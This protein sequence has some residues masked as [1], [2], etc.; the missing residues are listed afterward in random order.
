[1][2]T[3]RGRRSAAA[4]CSASGVLTAELAS[5]LGGTLEAGMVDRDDVA[6]LP[7]LAQAPPGLLVVP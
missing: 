1:M 6:P 7:V 4:R 2:T 3:G 5:D